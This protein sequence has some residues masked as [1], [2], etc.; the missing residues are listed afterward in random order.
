MDFHY[1]L[2]ISKEG[3]DAPAL[4]LIGTRDGAVLVC[5]DDVPAGSEIQLRRAIT[6]LPDAE[7][8]A[9]VG[10]EQRDYAILDPRLF[11]PVK[12]LV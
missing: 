9:D 10:Y 3:H 1:V 2:T 11:P 4:R 7:E 5:L 6:R 12:G 8:A